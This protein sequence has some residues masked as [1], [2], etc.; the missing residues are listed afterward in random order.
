MLAGAVI[1]WQGARSIGAGAILGAIGAVTCALLASW[2]IYWAVFQVPPAL[3]MPPP[4]P[5][6]QP[7]A[8]I[9]PDLLI[10]LVVA[11]IL[12]PVAAFLGGLG[13]LIGWGASLLT[14]QLRRSPRL[15]EP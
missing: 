7:R 2:L 6:L 14:H 4:D 3:W 1:A 15:E 5:S 8:V 11:F 9:R 10:L 13:G 12:A